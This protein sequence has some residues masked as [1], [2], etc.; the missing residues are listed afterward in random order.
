MR[1][2]RNVYSVFGMFSILLLMMRATLRYPHG[3]RIFPY[4]DGVPVNDAKHRG[5][6]DK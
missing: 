2:F 4:A 5:A 3:F 1:V 6:P